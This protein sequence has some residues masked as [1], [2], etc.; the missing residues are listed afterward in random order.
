MAST[1]MSSA[2]YDDARRHTTTQ[3]RKRGDTTGAGNE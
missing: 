2:S 3:I 1:V